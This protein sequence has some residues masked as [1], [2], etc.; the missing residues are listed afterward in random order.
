MLLRLEVEAGRPLPAKVS[1]ARTPVRLHSALLD[2]QEELLDEAVPGRA[3][4]AVMDHEQ[5]PSE[6]DPGISRLAVA[7]RDWA[8]AAQRHQD[9][10]RGQP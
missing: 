7:L 2:W 8:L 10:N 5:W 4:Y 3:A 1:E 9:P 6:T